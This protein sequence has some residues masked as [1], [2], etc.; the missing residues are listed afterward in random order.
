MRVE[1]K[2]VSTGVDTRLNSLGIAYKS[3]VAIKPDAF[4]VA[5]IA[6]TNRL[7]A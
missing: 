4:P 5:N 1:E 7:G 3:Y 2:E 6:P